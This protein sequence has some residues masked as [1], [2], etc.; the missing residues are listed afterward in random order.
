MSLF[1]LWPDSM[2]SVSL[3][4]CIVLRLFYAMLGEHLLGLGAFESWDNRRSRYPRLIRAIESIG[5]GLRS[6]G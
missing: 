6:I 5:L 3:F 1:F 4:V 2:A